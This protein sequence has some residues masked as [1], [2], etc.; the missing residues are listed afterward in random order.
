MD[1]KSAQDIIMESFEIVKDNYLRFILLTFIYLIVVFIIAALGFLVLFKFGIFGLIQSGSLSN[2]SPKFIYQIIAMFIS[3]SIVALIVEPI[4]IGA[5]YRLAAQCIEGNASISDAFRQSA[6]RYLPML[7]TCFLQ[8]VIFLALTIIIFSPLIFEGIAAFHNYLLTGTFSRSGLGVSPFL[9]IALAILTV[10]V[11]LILTI[12][13][14]IMFYQALPVVMLENIGGIAAIRR[15]IEICK[16]N[17][18]IVFILIVS[19][20]AVSSGIGWAVNIMSGFIGIIS[21]LVEIG[22]VVVCLIVLYNLFLGWTMVMP[23]VFNRYYGKK[24]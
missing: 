5:Y 15:S 3:L 2:M 1:P 7:W 19:T 6:K 11:Y 10:L 24:R 18:W 17:F 4:F 13:L 12:F 22:F 9:L 23:V 16:N 20:I 8:G 21:R 14:E